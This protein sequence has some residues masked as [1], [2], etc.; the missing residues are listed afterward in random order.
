ML[1]LADRGFFSMDRFLRF[2][3]TGA[4]LAWRVKNGGEMRPGQDRPRQAR[5]PGQAR[6]SYSKAP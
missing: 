3:A 6:D 5:V 1:N 2:S 4:H